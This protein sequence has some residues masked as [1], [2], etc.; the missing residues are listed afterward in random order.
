MYLLSLFK[1]QNYDHIAIALALCAQKRTLLS[2]FSRNSISFLI[3]TLNRG[4]TSLLGRSLPIRNFF[5]SG[6]LNGK[7]LFLVL[8]KFNFLMISL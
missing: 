5:Q 6:F 2:F 8:I 7:Q 1:S 3:L 4:K